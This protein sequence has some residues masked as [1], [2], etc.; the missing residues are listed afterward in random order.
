MISQRIVSSRRIRLIRSPVR[1]IQDF[2]SQEG[3]TTDH[4]RVEHT[5]INEEAG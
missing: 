2:G 1:L 5:L 4:V 3:M